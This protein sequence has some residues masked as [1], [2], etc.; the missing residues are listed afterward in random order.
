MAL[1]TKDIFLRSPYWLTIQETDLDFVLCELRIWTGLLSAEPVLADIKL[2]STA[3]NDIT[4]IDIAEFARDFIEVTFSGTAESNAVF[5]SYQ[6][7]HFTAGVIDPL[8][9][10]EAKV[11]LTGFDG[12]GTFQ[13][14]VNFSWNK[15]VMISDTNITTYADTNISIP[16]KQNLLTGYTLYEF[17]AG[18]GGN[19]SAFRTVT[20]LFPT[21]TTSDMI[22]QV[23][24]SYI[25]T[26]ASK[27][28]FEFSQGQDETVYIDYADCNVF[29]NTF[30]YFVNRLGCTQTMSF[31]GKTDVNMDTSSNKYTRNIIE[32]GDYDP[33]RHQSFV[34]NKNGKI[35]LNLNTGWR[36][37][38][39]NDTMI[40]MMLSEQVWIQIESDKLGVGWLPK[41]NT[42]WTVPVNMVSEKTLIKNKVNDKLINYSFSFEAAYDWINTVR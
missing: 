15:Q 34:L 21:E 18:Y 28:V 22:V 40:E 23:D 4:S 8:P 37:E 20:G 32:N 27:I 36:Q 26:Y 11:Y 10:K 9:A 7:Q 19:Y 31:F 16:V 33:T 29:G 35:S 17:A 39:E 41:T 25:G 2:R 3:L 13:D 14:G 42:T 24:T 1:P 30:V 12:Y 38:E 5:I 6:L